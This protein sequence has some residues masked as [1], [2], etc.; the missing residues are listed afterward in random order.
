MAKQQNAALN[1]LYE[2]RDSLERT[3]RGMI[4]EQY[5]NVE[6]MQ[7]TARQLAEVNAAIR[8]LEG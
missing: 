5:G 8:S 1:V 7:T 6:V 3:L 4:E 2:E